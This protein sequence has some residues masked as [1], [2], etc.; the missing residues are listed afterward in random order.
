[1]KT[2]QLRRTRNR[3]LQ[4]QLRA[5]IKDLRTE[6]DKARAAERY[7]ET[8]SLLDRAAAQGIIHKGNADRNKSRLAQVINRLG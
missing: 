2:S 5:T 7:R 1:M 4:S 8:A 3:A 6:T